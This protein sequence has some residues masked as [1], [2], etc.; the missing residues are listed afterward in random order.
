MAEYQDI[1][2]LN[3]EKYKA[4][5]GFAF[6]SKREQLKQCVQHE[7]WTVLYFPFIRLLGLPIV[8][9]HVYIQEIAILEL[10]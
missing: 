5:T 8:D 3:W 6:K 10:H 4:M 2:T 1:P 9:I 7:V